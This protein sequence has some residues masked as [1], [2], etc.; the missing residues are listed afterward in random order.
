MTLKNGRYDAQTE[1]EILDAMLADAKEYF[2]E[3]LN[4]TSL[5]IIRTFYR[6]I[7]GRLA[8]AQADIGLVLNSSQ[9]DYAEGQALDLLTALIGITRDEADK[10]SGTVKFSRD[11]AASTDYTIPT[12]TVVQTDSL[13]PVKFETTETVTLASGSTSV[14]ASA[15]AVEAG[16]QANVG[17]NTLVVMP[18][19]PTGVEDATNPSETQG[20][21]RR[22][23]DDELRQRAKNELA[24]GSRA[25]APALVNSVQRIEGV[26]SVS[27]FVNDTNNDNTGSGGLPDHA[28]ELVIAGGNKQTIGQTILETKA[29]GDTSYGGANGTGVTVTSDLPNG[30]T[31][32]VKFSRPTNVQ[33]YVDVS[34]EKTDEFAGTDAVKN[35]IVDYIGGIRTS[36]NE[37]TGLGVGEDVIYTEIMAQVQT[38]EGIH[39]VPTLEVGTTADPT[40]TSNVAIADSDVATSDGTDSSLTISTQN[41]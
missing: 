5:N 20:G 32:D 7:A 41:V 37:A 8:E 38:V 29:A 36:G 22:E 25:S 35:A 28:F 16:P 23:T 6:P 10:A 30:Q 15:E 40:G 17:A 3:D 33:I 1:G 19:P 21:H 12:G 27:I 11:T 31:H 24:Q 9:I 39:D 14:R 13:D 2:G 34:V 4:D 18:D 26:T